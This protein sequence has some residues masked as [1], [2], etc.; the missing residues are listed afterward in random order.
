MRA[1]DLPFNQRITLP[2]SVNESIELEMQNLKGDLK[3]ITKEVKS[4]VASDSN[5]RSEQQRGVKSLFQRVKE[6]EIVMFKTDKSAKIG[7]INTKITLRLFHKC[8]F[9]YIRSIK[10]G[11]VSYCF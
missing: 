5:L 6:E 3:K 11:M 4:E 8:F 7:S 10:Q 2:K 9:A 1:T